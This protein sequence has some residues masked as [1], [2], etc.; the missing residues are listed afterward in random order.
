[1]ASHKYIT[2]KEHNNIE[3]SSRTN[4]VSLLKKNRLKEKQER[5]KNL[6]IAAAAVSVLA[7][8][9]LIISQ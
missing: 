3:Y 2:P 7:I 1:M 4:V 5:N 9:G 8:S 6:Y